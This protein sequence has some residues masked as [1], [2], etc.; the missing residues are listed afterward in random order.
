MEFLG[1]ATT[2]TI[3]FRMLFLFIGALGFLVGGFVCWHEVIFH[4]RNGLTV[5]MRDL[6][7]S[8]GMVFLAF[9]GLTLLGILELNDTYIIT[10]FIAN[11]VLLLSLILFL[12]KSR[13]LLVKMFEGPDG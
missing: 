1:T 3:V 13:S 11:L 8:L 2:A 7:W 5:A 12:V 9:S 4:K 10:R 6:S